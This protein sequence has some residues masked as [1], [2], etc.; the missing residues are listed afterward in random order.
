MAKRVLAFLV[1]LVIV[2]TIGFVLFRIVPADSASHAMPKVGPGNPGMEELLDI[3]S[4]PLYSQ[5]ID[6]MYRTFTG[7]FGVVVGF[8]YAADYHISD[9]V[10]PFVLRSLFLFGVTSIL[11]ILIG[12]LYIRRVSKKQGRILDGAVRWVSAALF[13]LPVLAVIVLIRSAA[14]DT[15]LPVNGFWSE[16]YL[17]KNLV[18]KIADILEHAMLPM[19]SLFLCSVGAY[20]LILREGVAEAA[21]QG[22]PDKKGVA[23]SMLF[24]A[25]YMPFFFS[26]VFMTSMVVDTVVTYNG[27]G[28]LLLRTI[29]FGAR[30][31]L[32]EA[33]FFL[34]ALIVMVSSLAFELVAAAF[35]RDRSAFPIGSDVK[36]TQSSVSPSPAEKQ[37]VVQ[38]SFFQQVRGILSDFVHSWTGIVSLALLSVLVVIAILG[39]TIDFSEVR[40][41]PPDD[42][43]KAFLSASTFTVGTAIFLVVLPLAIGLVVGVAVGS[44]GKWFDWFS[45]TLFAALMAVPLA[46]LLV[47]RLILLDENTGDPTQLQTSWTMVRAVLTATSALVA[48]VVSRSAIM[49]IERHRSEWIPP[50]GTISFDR[51][52]RDVLPRVLSDAFRAAKYAAVVGV[53]ACSTAALW[54]V[55]IENSWGHMIVRA[56]DWDPVLLAE[57]GLLLAPM[58]GIALL[59]FAIYLMLNTAA[60]VTKKRYPD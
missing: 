60:Q 41:W 39:T 37:A 10:Y 26:W 20:F 40:Y 34:T 12:A 50:N 15:S 27:L 55:N 42:A 51:I 23:A 35:V 53:L 56:Y 49:V 47:P 32:L 38:G 8:W 4:K 33:I 9:F 14:M 13:S 25:P 45:T 44:L 22:G 48:V 54:R 58:L 31:Q 17:S 46:C 29:T 57:S 59:C 19:L 11:S 28:T 1:V 24:V 16:D 52:V 2:A 43:T 7:Q 5:Y 18:G 21:R 36:S 3:Y 6:Y 30:F